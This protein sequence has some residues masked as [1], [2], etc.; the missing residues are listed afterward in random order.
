MAD[1]FMLI[2]IEYCLVTRYIGIHHA[3]RLIAIL[4]AF[5][6]AACAQYPS[7]SRTN[8]TPGAATTSSLDPDVVALGKRLFFDDRLSADGWLSCASCHDPGHGFS[9]RRGVSVGVNGL[10]GKRHAPT[11]LGRGFGETQFWDGRAATLEE[12]VLQPIFNPEEMGMTIET[13]SRQLNNDPNYRGLTTQSLAA[14]LA[15]YVRSL[16]SENSDYDLFVSR[17]SLPISNLELEGLQLFRGKAQCYLC[18]SGPQFTDEKFHNTGVAW[19]DGTLQDEGRAAV[20]GKS[21]HRG[22]FKTPTLRNVGQRG[23]YMHDGSLTTLEDVVNFYDRGGNPNPYIDE[24]VVPLHL[25][26]G[27]KKA[28]LAFLRAGLT[29]TVKDGTAEKSPRRSAVNGQPKK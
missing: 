1:C 4:F 16:R 7:T 6:L 17:W 14:A 12:Q 9:D 26:A 27:E 15:G 8:A 3:T 13:L 5:T 18:H 24:N 11:L 2:A 28:L 22:A 21:Y 10:R 29:G 25:T 23:P 20:T 19:R